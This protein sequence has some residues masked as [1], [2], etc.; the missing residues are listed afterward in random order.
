MRQTTSSP[1]LPVKSIV[2][3]DRISLAPQP[4]RTPIVRFAGQRA[5]AGLALGDFD[6][7][8][9]RHHLHAIRSSRGG[10][11][12]G[13]GKGGFTRAAVEGLK[14]EPNTNYDIKVADVNGD[15]RPDVILMYESSSA[16]ALS[17]ERFDPRGSRSRSRSGGRQREEVIRGN[18]GTGHRTCGGR[19]T[20]GRS[21]CKKW[22][23]CRVGSI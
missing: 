11:L 18:P 21:Y 8:G 13:D 23:F 3:I 20:D 12:L 22:L 14:L 17:A 2:G 19:R 10:H 9:N 7:D 4:K 16:T 1:D 6:G 15:G 5:I